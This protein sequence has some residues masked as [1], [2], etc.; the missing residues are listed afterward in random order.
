MGEKTRNNNDREDELN[1]SRFFAERGA[2]VFEVE[3]PGEE[4][5][6]IDEQDI[7]DTKS[8]FREVP[9]IRPE[10][11]I[12]DRSPFYGQGFASGDDTGIRREA[13]EEG[14]EPDVEH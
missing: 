8:E 5:P 13:S 14:E 7:S 11:K 2:E 9:A 4:G 3:E 6:E 12:A 1:Q 10:S